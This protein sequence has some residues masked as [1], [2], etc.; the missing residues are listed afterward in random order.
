VGVRLLG[1]GGS[2]SGQFQ[3][4]WRGSRFFRGF[5]GGRL[6]SF[7]LHFRT[8]VPL[9]FRGKTPDPFPPFEKRAREDVRKTSEVARIRSCP[10][11][12]R[13]V[14]PLWRIP[15]AKCCRRAVFRK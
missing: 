15:H 11:V 13:N 4:G 7:G 6:V 2:G 14:A 9:V 3:K 12:R 1:A 10:N 8:S 5:A